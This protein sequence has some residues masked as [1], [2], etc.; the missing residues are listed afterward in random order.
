MDF[1]DC[2]TWLVQNKKNV[3]AFYYHPSDKKKMLQYKFQLFLLLLFAI[4]LYYFKQKDVEFYTKYFSTNKN[5]NVFEFTD[6]NIWY[7][8]PLTNRIQ[9]R[10]ECDCYHMIYIGDIYYIFT[11]TQD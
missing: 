1:K 11:K 3:V 9:D 5:S 10:N 4:I 7:E 6:Y 2:N 8:N